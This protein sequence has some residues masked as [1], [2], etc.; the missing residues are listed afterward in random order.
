MPSIKDELMER[1]KQFWNALDDPDFYGDVKTSQHRRK[2]Q[3]R[4]RDDATCSQAD[5]WRK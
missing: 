5:E 3:R 4:I 2:R 1:E